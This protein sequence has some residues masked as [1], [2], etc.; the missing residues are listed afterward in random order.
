MANTLTKIER[1]LR[2]ANSLLTR[3]VLLLDRNFL[4]NEV[5]SLLELKTTLRKLQI[6]KGKRLQEAIRGGK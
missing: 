6:C 5:Q 1:D 3:A 4:E 2:E